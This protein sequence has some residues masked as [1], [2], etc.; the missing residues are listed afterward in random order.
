MLGSRREAVGRAGGRRWRPSMRVRFGFSACPAGAGLS[1]APGWQARARCVGPSSAAEA[2][3]LEGGVCGGWRGRGR[4]RK[5]WREKQRNWCEQ[6]LKGGAGSGTH[7]SHG[8]P[9]TGAHGLRTREASLPAG[10]RHVGAALARHR[11]PR[12][13]LPLHAAVDGGQRQARQ[14]WR[15]LRVHGAVGHGG[16]LLLLLV[17]GRRRAPLPPLLLRL[18]EVRV[19]LQGGAVQHLRPG[20]WQGGRNGEVVSMERPAVRRQRVLRCQ[21]RLAA[22]APQHPT[23][24]AAAARQRAWL[25]RCCSAW[26]WR[27]AA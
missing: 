27:R 19:L 8:P 16:V 11:Q 25:R 1:A 12:L 21:R 4:R 17:C 20:W 14:R 13:H 9:T 5:S 7:A 10:G 15:R 24:A 18:R 3:A 2:A 26:C 23:A 22:S 6:A